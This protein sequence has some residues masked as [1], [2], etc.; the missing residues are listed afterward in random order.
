MHIWRAA[1]CDLE[2]SPEWEVGPGQAEDP[3]ALQA[4]FCCFQVQIGCLAC[5]STQREDHVGLL[6]QQQQGSITSWMAYLI[7]R[8]Q[9]IYH[10][11]IGC[12]PLQIDPVPTARYVMDNAMASRLMRRRHQ[13][14]ALSGL[15]RL[16][17]EPSPPSGV[18]VKYSFTPTGHEWK[19]TQSRPWPGAT[20]TACWTQTRR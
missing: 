14:Q 13:T 11:L 20:Y 9:G 2:S 6:E 10:A 7:S 15:S 18:A 1:D 5:M 16:H 4:F 3:A 17:A 12:Y 8:Y 19:Y